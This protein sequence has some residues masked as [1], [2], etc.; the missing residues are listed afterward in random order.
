MTDDERREC[1][2]QFAAAIGELCA[3]WPAANVVVMLGLPVEAGE[4][5]GE[6]VN[7]GIDTWAFGNVADFPAALRFFAQLVERKA[8]KG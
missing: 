6:V 2:K 8:P 1:Q 4:D 5:T 3:K 7:G